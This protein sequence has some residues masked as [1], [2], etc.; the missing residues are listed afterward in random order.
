MNSHYYVI[1]FPGAAT[2]D[3]DPQYVGNEGE[4]VWDIDDAKIFDRASALTAMAADPF[5]KGESGYF[6][7]LVPIR[8]VEA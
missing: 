8:P 4:L 6:A 3:I 5:A 2:R 7:E 1:K